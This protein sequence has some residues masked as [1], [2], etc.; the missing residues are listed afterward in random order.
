MANINVRSFFQDLLVQDAGIS[1]MVCYD[2]MS[3]DS[4][5]AS[6]SSAVRA[7]A[8]NWDLPRRSDGSPA[9]CGFGTNGMGF[10]TNASRIFMTI[11]SGGTGA[12]SQ[13]AGRNPGGLS[14]GGTTASGPT[15]VTGS[16][17]GD[18]GVAP[19]PYTDWSVTGS[20]RTAWNGTVTGTGT[21]SVIVAGM[22]NHAATSTV[23]P[24]GWYFGDPF[25]SRQTIV[26]DIWYGATG[27]ATDMRVQAIRQVHDNNSIAAANTTFV[28]SVSATINHAAAGVTTT[29]SDCGSGPG[30]PGRMLVNPTT[31]SGSTMR[32][33]SIGFRV[34][35]SSAGSPIVGA[36]LAVVASPGTYAQQHASCMGKSGMVAS[37]SNAYEQGP[38]PYFSAANARTYMTALCGYSGNNYATHIVIYDGHNRTA[39]ENTELATGISATHQAN[40]QA[41]IDQHV[42]NAA[43]NGA[44]A[45]KFLI[46]RGGKMKDLYDPEASRRPIHLNIGRT[47]EKT[48]IEAG[49]NVSYIDMFAETDDGDATFAYGMWYSRADGS[50]GST[51]SASSGPQLANAD[52]VHHSILGADKFW[53]KVWQIGMSACSM[54]TGI[55]LRGTRQSEYPG[56]R[57]RIFGV[58]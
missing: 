16:T 42:A 18:S 55:V 34:F 10:T 58:R 27:G 20:S 24:Q 8:D 31:P 44:R 21:A 4:V 22:N 19:Q 32:M 33:Y 13:S 11:N 47:L 51:A 12:W 15:T 6:Q 54:S 26:R 53:G 49:P 14:P 46:V 38:D 39:T 17:G 36:H 52:G 45:P 9:W 37:L 56:K 3:S 43:A 23:G 48:V 2:S 25:N 40:V 57:R 7:I 5:V 41:I 50:V 29:D 30:C 1:L 28:G 35:R